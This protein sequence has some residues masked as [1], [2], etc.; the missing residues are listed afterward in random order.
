MINTDWL[1]I[2]IFA[3]IALF[4]FFR[5]RHVLGQKTGEE[6]KHGKI[7]PPN[8]LR[9]ASQRSQDQ[10]VVKDKMDSDQEIASLLT[11]QD[12]VAELKNLQAIFPAFQPSS[13][14]KGAKIAFESILQA[15]AEGD[16]KTLKT[17]VDQEIF[18][19]FSKAITDR[20][21]KG[22]HQQTL[23]VAV[24]EAQIESIK[25]ENNQAFV[26][27]LLVSEQINVIRSQDGEVIEGNETAVRNIRDLW[28]FQKDLRNPDPNWLLVATHNAED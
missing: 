13:F 8:P 12:V 14:L 3:A 27:T 21:N 22:H 16:I 2:I 5:L 23:I 28:T 9:P 15:Y 6:H 25:V 7:L 19:A 26:T 1:Q 24:N 11:K 20:Q 17:L 18:D 10:V 4:F